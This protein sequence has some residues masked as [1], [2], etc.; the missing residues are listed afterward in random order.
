[1]TLTLNV[2][3]YKSLEAVIFVKSVYV[4]F[5]NNNTGAHVFLQPNS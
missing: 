3:L 4:V 1:M 5:F 2:M